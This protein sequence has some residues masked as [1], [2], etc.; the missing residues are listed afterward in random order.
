[1]TIHIQNLRVET[2]LGV[3]AEERQEKREVIINLWLGLDTS[4]A[5]STDALADTVDYKSIAHQVS[6][7]VERSHYRLLESLAN[8]IL[9]EVLK[10]S[11]LNNVRV[12]VSKPKA[13]RCADCVLVVASWER[14]V[15]QS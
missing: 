10:N 3:K 6:T 7:A 15:G 14:G 11:R 9:C 12:E 13:L 4:K 1:M 5:I 2:V 8:H